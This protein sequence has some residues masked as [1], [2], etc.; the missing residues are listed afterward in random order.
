[1]VNTPVEE[2]GG[3]LSPGCSAIGSH[4]SPLGSGVISEEL[5]SAE[6][7]VYED[8]EELSV[9]ESSD[10]LSPVDEEL[11]PIS[12]LSA[13]EAKIYEQTTTVARS[14]AEVGEST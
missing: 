10:E 6:E 7:E 9:S 1:M 11:V 3:K 13:E 12:V 14:M 8:D 5:F 2:G 4:S